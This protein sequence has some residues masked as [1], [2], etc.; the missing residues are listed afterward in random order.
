MGKRIS[1]VTAIGTDVITEAS[2]LPIT[3]TGEH[4]E[5]STVEGALQEAGAQLS[6]IDADLEELQRAVY[7]GAV[8]G[9]YWDGTLTNSATRIGG[10][11]GKV[12]EPTVGT[13]LGR[14]D[15]ES[16]RPWSN[17]V[18]C[19][20]ADDGTVNAFEGEPTFTL[21]GSNGQVMVRIPKFYYR[22]VTDGYARTW[23]IAADPVG[24]LEV[25]PAFVAGG[26]EIDAIYV[27][28]YMGAEESGKLVS[29]TGVL[30]QYNKTRSQFRALA[31]ARGA[32]P[33]GSGWGICDF[34]SYSALQLLML[35]MVGNLN[36]QDTIGRG[37]CD[38]PYSDSHTAQLTETAVSRAVVTNAVAAEYQVNWQIS[39]GTTRGGHQ[40]ANQRMIT[41]IT[42]LG[43]GT[44]A[45]EFDGASVDVTAGNIVYSMPQKTGWADDLG[46]HSGRGSG[47][48]GKDEI[49]V[50]GVQGMWGN[51]WQFLD[52]A[53]MDS[54]YYMW[55][56]D[57]PQTYVDD[58]FA[59]PYERLESQLLTGG[60]G[61]LRSFSDDPDAPWSMMIK[62]TGGDNVKPVGDYYY[63]NTTPA[64]RVLIVG[65]P[66]NSGSI[67]GPW[68]WHVSTTSSAAS[69][70]NG[71]R[72][73]YKPV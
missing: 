56:A 48:N 30:P 47:T 22:V 7:T 23:Y 68:S 33:D 14:N 3:D 66:W 34:L 58:T 35:V 26:V 53:N 27:S 32:D 45:I 46:S 60:N 43:D 1:I 61:Y 28:A 31:R 5:S 21:D 72:L 52:G 41:S 40:V 39:I 62:E 55:F 54:S 59:T 65:G 42:D 51:W 29:K 20:L 17:V 73:L 44:S 67:D 12:F 63:M 64:N 9:L 69:W 18:R 38:M 15:F 2:Q 71:A 19:N 50:L 11:V 8:Y 36:A 6:A 37:F 25:H 13:T 4:Y 49:C 16:I 24:G 57:D 10:A 70:I